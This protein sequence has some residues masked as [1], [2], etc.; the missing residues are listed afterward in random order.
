MLVEL[1]RLNHVPGSLLAAA[2]TEPRST[3]TDATSCKPSP[4]R[5]RTARPSPSSRPPRTGSFRVLRWCRWA[6]AGSG[7]ATRPRNSWRPKPAYSAV[8]RRSARHHHPFS[9]RRSRGALRPGDT[10]A[11]RSRRVL[12]GRSRRPLVCDDHPQGPRPHLRPRVPPRQPRALR[13]RRLHRPFPRAA[14]EPPYLTGT[15]ELDVDHHGAVI[16]DPMDA[17]RNALQRSVRDRAATRSI[18]SRDP[19]AGI[20][21]TTPHEISSPYPGPEPDEGIELGL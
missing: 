20:A 7:S 5:R 13:R 21:R 3:S 15:D 2:L 11:V 1:G 18:T 8:Q 4:T 19:T 14:R 12:P 6:S 17:I 16:D 10:V 9:E